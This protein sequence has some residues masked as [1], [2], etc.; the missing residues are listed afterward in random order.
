VRLVS[1]RPLGLA[2]AAAVT[3]AGPACHRKPEEALETAGAVAVEVEAARSGALTGIVRATGLVQPAPGA[4]W[5]VVAPQSA[6]IVTLP[7]AAGDAVRRGELLARFDSPA[8]RS[9]LASHTSVLAQAEAKADN[10]RKNQARLA[11]LLERG[12]ASRKEVED[13]RKDLQDAEAALREA[14]AT[15]AASADLAA[16]ATAVAR[17]DGIVAERWHNPGEVVDAGE[18]VLRLIDPSRL[19]VSASVAVADLGRIVVGHP[20]R[21]LVPGATSEDAVPAEV[22]SGP[23]AVDAATGA[24]SVRL[25]LSRPLPVG[26]PVQVEIEAEQRSDAVIVPAAAVVRDGETAAVFVVDAE[27]KAHRRQV[28]LGLQAGTDVE[29]VSGVKPGDGV[30]VRGQEE[31]P[32]GAAVTVEK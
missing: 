27:G 3:L 18:H 8:L 7:K 22:A 1:Q 2:V 10:S 20:A 5:T 29:V 19:Q 31:L 23:A 28:T 16:R 30:I 13:A 21:V 14:K 4:D 15:L 24:A 11:A 9:D 12:I 17:F 26:A 25:A 6:R 32:D